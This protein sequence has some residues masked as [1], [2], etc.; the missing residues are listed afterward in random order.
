MAFGD[1]LKIRTSRAR[2]KVL[3][4][5]NR[6]MG[7]RLSGQKIGSGQLRSKVRSLRR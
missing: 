1:K 2:T 7:G 3:S 6:L 4:F 5:K